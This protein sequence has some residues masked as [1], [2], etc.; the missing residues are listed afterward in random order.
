[1]FNFAV[2]IGV[3]S[4]SARGER[5]AMLLT[6]PLSEADGLDFNSPMKKFD[7]SLHKRNWNTQWPKISGVLDKLNAAK[8]GDE[9]LIVLNTHG[10]RRSQEKG[11]RSHDILDPDGR[12]YDLDQMAPAIEEAIKR[13]AKVALLDFSC[14]SGNSQ[15]LKSTGACVISDAPANYYGTS[16]IGNLEFPASFMKT[17]PR[18]GKHISLQ[19]HFLSSRLSSKDPS[20]LP[21]MSSIETPVAMAWEALYEFSDPSGQDRRMAQKKASQ[22]PDEISFHDLRCDGRRDQFSKI[23]QDMDALAAKVNGKPGDD[24]KQIAAQMHDAL[25][26]YREA[27]EKIS[28]ESDLINAKEHLT[29]MTAVQAAT[30]RPDDDEHK[31]TLE[32]AYEL[33]RQQ[34]D[35]MNARFEK[36]ISLERQFYQ[37]SY[38]LESLNHLT[39]KERNPCEQFSL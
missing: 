28:R 39:R 6:P 21:Q 9:V 34:E 36:L 3:S 4:Q 35:T 17:L 26:E 14:F 31:Q 13:G 1:M 11:Q 5:T 2:L 15:N 22:H 8:S 18:D 30:D 25:N 24:L 29:H 38:E 19:Q 20:N 12:I 32:D 7:T 37:K 23:T 16:D 33:Y 10:G 27:Y